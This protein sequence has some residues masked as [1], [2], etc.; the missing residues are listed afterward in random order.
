M[1][2]PWISPIVQPLPGQPEVTSISS[3]RYSGASSTAP[4][5]LGCRASRAISVPEVL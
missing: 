3:I 5:T 2:P 4:D 1:A